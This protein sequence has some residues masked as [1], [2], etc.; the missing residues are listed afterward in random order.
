[1]AEETNQNDV[2]YISD[3]KGKEV[4][5]E[6]VKVIEFEGDDYAILHPLEKFESL[7]EDSCVIFLMKDAENDSV[8]L[9]PIEDE[10]VLD[11]VYDLYVEWATSE[12]DDGCT[13]N[14]GG[15]SGCH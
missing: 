7:Q 6:V 15:C 5:F 8:D 3:S 10:N 14:C 1:M 2:V 12:S 4:P 11:S 13:G 9:I